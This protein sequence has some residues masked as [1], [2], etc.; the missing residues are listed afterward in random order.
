M[1]ELVHFE[2]FSETFECTTRKRQKP[3]VW[4]LKNKELRS[5]TSITGE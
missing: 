1:E 5:I 3:R 2:E 4:R